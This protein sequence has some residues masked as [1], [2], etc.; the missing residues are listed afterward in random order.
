MPRCGCPNDRQVRCPCEVTGMEG[1][2]VTGDGTPRT[3][4]YVISL[5]NPGPGIQ[6]E[7]TDTLDLTLGDGTPATL[8]GDVRL[9]GDDQ[10]ALEQGSDGGLY[11][12][13]DRV[14]IKPKWALFYQAAPQTIPDGESV[15]IRWD[16]VEPDAGPQEA[17]ITVADSGLYVVAAFARF[18]G[19][20]TANRVSLWM[21]DAAN[22]EARIT[23]TDPRQFA[24]RTFRPGV[25]FSEPVWLNQGQRISVWL[26]QASGAE[27]TTFT[28]YKAT[29]LAVAYLGGGT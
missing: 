1:V 6:V 5:A 16:A 18:D 29:R 21:A 11:V 15:P 26:F 28:D 13:A 9:S 7:D 23:G 17:A 20:L 2:V 14:A 3:N 24:E 8:S 10:N 19:Y 12:H 4:P 25:H 22:S 27:Q